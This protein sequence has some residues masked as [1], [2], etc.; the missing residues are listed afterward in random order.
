M[1]VRMVQES[2]NVENPEQAKLNDCHYYLCFSGELNA[3]GDDSDH[4]YKDQSTDKG[5]PVNIA[6]CFFTTAE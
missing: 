6:N 5:S 2:D 3:V 4:K 1:G